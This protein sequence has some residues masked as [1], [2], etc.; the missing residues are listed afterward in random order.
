MTTLPPGQRYDD[1]YFPAAC[2]AMEKSHL[3]DGDYFRHVVWQELR[4]H[5]ESDWP[6]AI[7]YLKAEHPEWWE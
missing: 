4:A 3:R 2:R 7:R 5:L 6:A 1:S